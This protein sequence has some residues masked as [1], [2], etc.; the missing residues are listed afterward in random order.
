ML[1]YPAEAYN[2]YVN[3]NSRSLGGVHLISL[4]RMEVVGQQKKL[5]NSQ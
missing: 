5:V 1:H 4:Q 3:E 2:D